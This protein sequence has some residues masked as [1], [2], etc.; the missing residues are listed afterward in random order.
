MNRKIL[1]AA[2]QC[3]ALASPALGA[4]IFE[5]TF[6]RRACFGR[7]YDA[8]HLRQHPRQTVGGISLSYVPTNVDGVRNTAAHFELGLA[9]VLKQGGSWYT[10]TASCTTVKT[11]FECSL[12]GDGGS[13]RVTPQAGSLRFAVVNR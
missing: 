4:G 12:E 5:T 9:F 8:A 6:A 3:L 2:C 1:A 11:A 10:G 7:N 13:F